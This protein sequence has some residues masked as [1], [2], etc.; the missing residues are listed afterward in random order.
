MIDDKALSLAYDA[1]QRAGR[2]EDAVKALREAATDREAAETKLA[3]LAAVVRA[4]SLGPLCGCHVTKVTHDL[5][6]EAL[7]G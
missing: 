7:H 4:R 6:H 3:E 5:L 1:A 2:R